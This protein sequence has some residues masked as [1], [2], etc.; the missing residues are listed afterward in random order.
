MSITFFGM[1]NLSKGI[2]AQ[3][4]KSA[5]RCAIRCAN[6][7]NMIEHQ[8]NQGRYSGGIQKKPLNF[9]IF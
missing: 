2:G 4:R 8:Q 3:F 7:G 6:S 9:L 5:L 1:Y